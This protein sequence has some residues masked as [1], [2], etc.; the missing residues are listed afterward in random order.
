MDRVLPG[1]SLPIV[2]SIPDQFSRYLIPAVTEL[3]IVELLALFVTFG[4]ENFVRGPVVLL[5]EGV[6]NLRL[7]G[8]LTLI[9]ITH[10][11]LGGLM[12]LTRYPE[13]MRENVRRFDV[14]QPTDSWTK[15]RDLRHTPIQ[16]LLQQNRFGT[17]EDETIQ[18]EEEVRRHAG[19]M[20]LLTDLSLAMRTDPLALIRGATEFV[21]VIYGPAVTL[22]IPDV[23]VEAYRR[24]VLHLNLISAVDGSGLNWCEQHALREKMS[25]DLLCAKISEP[26][27]TVINFDDLFRDW[28]G[29]VDRG[30]IDRSSE[31]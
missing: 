10:G 18:K 3:S 7:D 2:F 5:T 24:S 19:G 1:K 30:H 6:Q 23:K 15:I 25:E 27:M 14:K 21:T 12:N 22:A 31:I 28:M 9:A 13:Q 8:L 29:E 4:V 26:E 20:P 16:Y 11:N 17:G